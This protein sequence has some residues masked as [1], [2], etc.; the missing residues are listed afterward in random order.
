MP[1]PTESWLEQLLHRH[2]G[3]K[4][5]DWFLDGV[6]N[7][8]NV[9][10][11][12]PQGLSIWWKRA[13]TIAAAG[14]LWVGGY[15]LGQGGGWKSA[16]ETNGAS[17][18]A[19]ELQEIMAIYENRDILQSWGMLGDADLELGFRDAEGGTW[20]LDTVDALEEELK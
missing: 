8:L 17:L 6:R 11:D 5:P 14:L 19:T 4:A 12:P 15:F 3:E 20:L 10:N 18:T 2:P 13:A 9:A 1:K 16:T 7:R